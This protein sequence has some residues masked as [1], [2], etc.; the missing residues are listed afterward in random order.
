MNYE[1]IVMIQPMIFL[2]ERILGGL[3]SLVKR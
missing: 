1:K 2:Q 3:M